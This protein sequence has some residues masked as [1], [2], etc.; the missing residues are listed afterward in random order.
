M[1]YIEVKNYLIDKGFKD[2]IT[3]FDKS[4]A[5]VKLAAEAIGCNENLIAKSI[6][7][8]IVNRV[9]MIVA[10]GDSKIQNRKYKD[11]F[12]TKAKMLGYEE[13]KEKVG[14]EVGGVCSFLVNKDVEIYLDESLK[15]FEKVYLACGSSNTVVGL[16]LD[17]LVEIVDFVKWIDVC[18]Y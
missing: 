3:E 4:S 1:S 2:R 8:K 9:I 6:T 16:K 14:H 7:F 11:E 18:K 12:Q 13:T 15:R 17:E 5:T 10:S